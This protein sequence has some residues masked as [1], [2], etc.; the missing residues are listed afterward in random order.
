MATT[1]E[2]KGS[3][4]SHAT[5]LTTRVETHLAAERREKALAELRR[6]EKSEL[7]SL[8]GFQSE[9]SA[10]LKQLTSI[11]WATLGKSVNIGTLEEETKSIVSDLQAGIDLHTEIL[12][13]FAEGSEPTDAVLNRATESRG[14][15]DRLRERLEGLHDAVSKL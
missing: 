10:T 15:A 9:F 12:A 1:S 2:L 13:T 14:L 11:D 8:T 6:V 3:L 5:R 4:Q 7:A